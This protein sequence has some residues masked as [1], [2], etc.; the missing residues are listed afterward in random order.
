MSPQHV[1]FNVFCQ[2]MS[3][4]YILYNRYYSCMIDIEKLKKTLNQRGMYTAK[5]KSGDL[6]LSRTDRNPELQ[7]IAIEDYAKEIML[8]GMTVDAKTLQIRN[9]GAAKA[10]PAEKKEGTTKSSKPK[11]QVYTEAELSELG[12]R[13]LQQLS[14]GYDDIPGNLS[15][16][17]MIAK[18][19]GK[20]KPQ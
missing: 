15:K 16:E 7:Y 20:P 1:G 4:P 2:D 9:T 14:K 8:R 11:P 13:E 12:Y 10:P 17:K 5:N 18:L 19:T 3:N 6:V